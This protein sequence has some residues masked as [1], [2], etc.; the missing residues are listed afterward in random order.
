MLQKRSGL[1]LSI[2]TVGA[3][4]LGS[5]TVTAPAFAQDNPMVGGA[6]MM[7]DM[8]IVE[9][10]SNAPNLTTLV[11]AVQ[12]AQLVETLSGEGP[13]TVFAPTNEAFEE[14]PAETLESVMMDENRAMLQGILTYHVVP[15]TLTSAD[16]MRMIEEGGGTANLKTV[17]GGTIT[18]RMD[19]DNIVIIDESD[20]GAIIETA[21]VMQSNGVVHVIDSVLMPSM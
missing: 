4:A 16:L 9:N 21:D 6:P 1:V 10:A 3:L 13:F 5:L 2:A 8:T 17:A 7:A 18:A 19:G 11:A 20:G 12:Q 15:G 14:V